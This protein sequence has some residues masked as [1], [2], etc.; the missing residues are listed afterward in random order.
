M[1]RTGGKDMAERANAQARKIL[2]EHHPEYVTE[3]EAKEIDK[4]AKAAQE[5]S[6][7][8]WKEDSLA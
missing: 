7:G 8:N 5:W 3:A 4:I 2:A 6:V 1:M